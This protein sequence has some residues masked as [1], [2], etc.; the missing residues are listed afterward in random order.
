[1][2]ISACAKARSVRRVHIRNT[3]E[4][5]HPRFDRRSMVPLSANQPAFFD[6]PSSEL[7]QKSAEAANTPSLPSNDSVSTA[8]P[9]H[10]NAADATAERALT[11]PEV[12]IAVT[13]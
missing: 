12:S 3:F 9:S 4:L 10:F 6:K 7:P 8:P 11:F 1:M 2:S 13:K 5:A